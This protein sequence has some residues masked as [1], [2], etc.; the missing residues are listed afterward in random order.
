S[1]HG[2]SSSSDSVLDSTGEAW[3]THNRQPL[4]VSR[5][6]LVATAEPPAKTPSGVSAPADST[7]SR[8]VTGASPP[9][10][11]ASTSVRKNW[12]YGASAISASHER[13]TAARPRIG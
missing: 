8:Q 1:R 2:V 4:D 10:T 13:I 11:L 9:V 6:T 12:M 3:C 7:F 5:N